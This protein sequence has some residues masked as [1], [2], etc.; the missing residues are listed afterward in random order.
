M[1]VLDDDLE[2]MTDWI[3]GMQ[4]ILCVAKAAFRLREPVLTNSSARLELF[5]MRSV[6]SITE[7]TENEFVPR[8]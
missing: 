6:D 4:G 7:S 2:M 8:V 5:S 1:C 3:L